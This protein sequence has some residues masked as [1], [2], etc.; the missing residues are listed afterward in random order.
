MRVDYGTSKINHEK[1]SLLLK[2]RVTSQKR[3]QKDYESQKAVRNDSAP[4]LGLLY[5]QAI[6]MRS[7]TPIIMEILGHELDSKDC[8]LI[9]HGK[10]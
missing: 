3:G 8:P 1:P 4:F 5:R 10:L 9:R 2:P 6:D 7:F